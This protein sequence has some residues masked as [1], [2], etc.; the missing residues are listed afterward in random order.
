[1]TLCHQYNVWL[2]A[3]PSFNLTGVVCYCTLPDVG[4]QWHHTSGGIVAPGVNTF[5]PFSNQSCWLCS[6]RTYLSP[7]GDG[8]RKERG[9]LTDTTALTKMQAELLS[10]TNSLLGPRGKQGRMPLEQ[11]LAR[12][13]TA[14]TT[15]V[16]GRPQVSQRESKETF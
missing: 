2:G 14:P 12:S 13:D 6:N 8:L 15:L 4:T 11:H 9:D 1:M 16:I 3:N 7:P 10:S 5:S